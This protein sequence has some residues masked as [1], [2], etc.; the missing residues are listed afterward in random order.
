M[1]ITSRPGRWLRYLAAPALTLGVI[2]ALPG[3]GPSP[4]G[5]RTRADAGLA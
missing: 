5:R 4:G 2:V 3:A 1:P